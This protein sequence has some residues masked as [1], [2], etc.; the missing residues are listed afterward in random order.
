M[1]NEI[2]ADVQ[3]FAT[4]LFNMARSGDLQLLEYVD[5]GVDVDLTNQDGNSVLMLA[6]YAG[7]EELVRGLLG[8]GASVDKQNARGQSILAGAV[9]KGEETIARMLID[10]HANPDAGHPSAR[11]TAQMFGRA[12]LLEAMATTRPMNPGHDA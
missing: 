3:E 9:F 12:A 5:A 4:A 8:R 6:A 7:H 10:A 11:E 1:T 2:P